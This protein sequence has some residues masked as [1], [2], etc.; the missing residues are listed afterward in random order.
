MLRMSFRA[1]DLA[2]M[3]A[4]ENVAKIGM[5]TGRKYLVL[6]LAFPMIWLIETFCQRL[7]WIEKYANILIYPAADPHV[8]TMQVVV[9]FENNAYKSVLEVRGRLLLTGANLDDFVNWYKEEKQIPILLGYTPSGQ[10]IQIGKTVEMG[11][12]NQSFIAR[13]YGIVDFLPEE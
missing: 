11:Y 3:I 10:E 6:K 12:S 9:R 13:S 7:G 2:L 5:V 1:E 8:A 4:S